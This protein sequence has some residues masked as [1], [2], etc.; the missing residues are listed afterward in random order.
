MA[1]DVRS[2]A[3]FNFLLLGSAKINLLI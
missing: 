3:I 1:I 2:H